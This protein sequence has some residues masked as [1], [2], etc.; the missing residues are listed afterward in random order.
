[1]SHESIFT[2]A[3]L[4]QLAT[5]CWIGTRSLHPS[6][7][8]NL[9]HGDWLKGRKLLINPEL[10]GPIKTT[11]QQ[12]RKFLTRNALPFPLS[13]LYLVPKDTID[14]VDGHLELFKN[15]FW[16]KVETFLDFYTEARDEARSFLGELFSEADYP[17]NI[18]EKF[19]FE[20]RFVTLATPKQASILSP[21]VYQREK[22]K[23]QALMDE[24]REIAIA[25]LREE[26]GQIVGHMVGKLSSNDGKP[27]AF[28]SSMLNRIRE[29]LDTFGDRN[30]FGDET[31][32]QLVTEARNLVGDTRSSHFGYSVAYNEV[33]RQK[34]TGQMTQLKSAIDAAIEELPRRRIRL[35][36]T[37]R[38]SLPEAA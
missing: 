3:C 7:M 27:R 19:S 23:F 17:M 5:S 20:W 29:F 36:T 8:E 1:M 22:Q 6:Q 11:I 24:T 26:F 31:L 37:D 25:A 33:L 2:K 15:E 21:E 12:A 13:G 28:K 30:L 4:I 10:L 16:S 35:D 38:G 34:I 14:D 9:G 18:R 32:A